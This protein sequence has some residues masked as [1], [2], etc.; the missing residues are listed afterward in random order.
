MKK[1][2]MISVVGLLAGGCVSPATQMI[3]NKF[4]DVQVTQP[5]VTGIWTTAAAGGLSTIKLNQDGTGIMCE[6]N[7]NSVNV[8]Q[9]RNSGNLIYAQN[10][11]ALK[12]ITINNQLLNVKTTF[13]AFN[14]DMKYRA[15][16]ELKLATPRCAKE[17]N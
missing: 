10:G 3:D 12:K 14:A 17:I 7:G 8:Y 2:L 5:E 1:I 4:L 11:M 15:D 9:L 13:S 6:D 16:N